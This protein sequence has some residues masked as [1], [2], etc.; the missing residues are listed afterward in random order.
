MGNKEDIKKTQDKIIKITRITG[1]TLFLIGIA[2]IAIVSVLKKQN[3]LPSPKEGTII[4]YE[5]MSDNIGLYA[6][7][8]T[9][10]SEQYIIL[11]SME[12]YNNFTTSLDTWY[13]D[14]I[15][16][17]TNMVN[18][19]E[20]ITEDVKQNW[21]REYK[22]KNDER[23]NK[24]KKMLSNTTIKEETFKEKSV[25]VI[26]DIT[27][28]MV[29]QENELEDICLNNGIL[30]IHINK[31]VIGVVG[32]STSSMYFVELDKSY[33]KDNK[34]NIV[35]SDINNSL[36]DV[37]Y[38]PIIYIYPEEEQIVDVKLGYKEN[39]LVS[40][41]VYD[42]GWNV[43]AKPDGTLIDNKTNRELYSLYYESQNK[44]DFKIEEDGFVISKEE[45]I[46]FL[47][48]K[49][50]ILGL[51]PREQEEFIIYWLPILQKNNYTYIRFAEQ[52]EIN[53]NMPLQIEPKPQTTIR[54]LMTFKGLE[55]KINVKEQELTKVERKGYTVIEW[56]ATILE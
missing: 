24:I 33:V 4:E 49:L 20:N 11:N 37:A 3:P 56:G 26:E 41:P 6:E 18:T 5:A 9:L 36:P 12:D 54:V 47:E 1:A 27:N 28:N 53:K 23:Y 17:Y 38:K 35:V 19:S 30:T 42:E 8:D 45:L 21:I 16:N 48:E 51:N 2:I 10:L 44:I 40:Y 29:L 50:E 31:E 22:T 55:N 25:I 39:L 32:D 43:L 13:Q 7:D 34:I 15:I 46:P 14:A 52:E